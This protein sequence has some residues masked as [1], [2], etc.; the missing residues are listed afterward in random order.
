MAVVALDITKCIARL[1]DDDAFD[2][3]A[4]GI[5]KMRDLGFNGLRRAVA[6]RTLRHR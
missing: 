1:A 6:F 5:A 3:R 4:S 2:E